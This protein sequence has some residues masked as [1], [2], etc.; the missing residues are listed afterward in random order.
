[1]NQMPMPF[2][3]EE[4]IYPLQFPTKEHEVA[5]KRQVE[6]WYE[7]HGEIFT[8]E[9]NEIIFVFKGLSQSELKK[10]NK[11]YTDS[12]ERAEYICRMCV[13][14][15]QIED[16]SLEIYAGVPETICRIILEESGFT[17]DA[18]KINRLLLEYENQMNGVEARIPCIIKEV[19]QDIPFEEIEDWPLEK[20]LYYYT[21]AK[22]T[23]ENLRG[24]QLVSDDEAAQ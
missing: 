22:W 7:E 18:S 3:E 14:E 19:F 23:L 6:E 1:M 24:V 15:P 20:T 10:A 4:E 13:L 21:R 9:V 11:L 17:T 12:L 16:Y 2:V 5:F 8:T